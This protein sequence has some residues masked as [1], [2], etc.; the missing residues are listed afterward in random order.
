MVHVAAFIAHT[1]VGRVD[2]I[3]CD[4]TPSSQASFS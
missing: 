1:L 4:C 2:Q 3:Q